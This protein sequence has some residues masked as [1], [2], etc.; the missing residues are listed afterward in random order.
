MSSFLSWSSTPILLGAGGAG[1][2]GRTARARG[3]ARPVAPGWAPVTSQVTLPASSVCTTS[4][5][6]VAPDS[7]VAV[8]SNVAPA[9]TLMS[10]GHS[11]PVIVLSVSASI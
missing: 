1:R 10:S 6:N 8:H 2:P 4:T 9:S 11:T 7:S 5:V 3:A